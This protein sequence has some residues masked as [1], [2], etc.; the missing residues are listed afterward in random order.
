[1]VSGAVSADVV[2]GADGAHSFVRTALL[3]KRR[4]PRAIAIRGYASTTPEMAGR[5]V[6]RGYPEAGPGKVQQVQQAAL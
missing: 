4:E 5:Q 2:V 1:M 6:I 3:G